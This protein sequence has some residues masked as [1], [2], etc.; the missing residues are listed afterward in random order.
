[1]S[2]NRAPRPRFVGDTLRLNK[3]N[4]IVPDGVV[5]SANAPEEVSLEELFECCAD[6]EGSPNLHNVLVTS[7]GCDYSFVDSL[8]RGSPADLSGRVT[9]FDNQQ[10]HARKMGGFDDSTYPGRTVVMPHFHSYDST[11]A[12]RMRMRRGTMHPKLSILEFRAAESAP[13]D[14]F[15]RLIVSSA[16]LGRYDSKVNNQ[17]WVHDFVPRV[18]SASPRAREPDGGSG[19]CPIC[20][21]WIGAT[22]CFECAVAIRCACT[23]H[24]DWGEAF[25]T[26]CSVRTALH[27][28]LCRFLIHLFGPTREEVSAAAGRHAIAQ[29][30]RPRPPSAVACP[31][32]LQRRSPGKLLTHRLTHA[33]SGNVPV[34]ARPAL[35]V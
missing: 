27:H 16:N 26:D 18:R 30:R 22:E 3:L 33:A 1:M 29:A 7:Y 31:L 14:R 32:A 2:P 12:E 20:Q 28:D 34:V 9:I 13:C 24:H 25:C 35:R 15:L 21:E 23:R 10:D 8:V 11:Q 19:A 5:P 4:V 17:Y 6:G